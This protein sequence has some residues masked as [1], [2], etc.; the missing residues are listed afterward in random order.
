MPKEKLK[1]SAVVSKVNQFSTDQQI[2]EH[3]KIIEEIYVFLEESHAFHDDMEEWQT[4]H[5]LLLKKYY[6]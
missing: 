3:L 2:L 6:L 5:F 1:L 4:L